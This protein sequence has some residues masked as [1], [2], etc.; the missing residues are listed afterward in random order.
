[1]RFFERSVNPLMLRREM[2]FKNVGINLEYLY[3]SL[4]LLL[5]HVKIFPSSIRNLVNSLTIQWPGSCVADR[6]PH[7]FTVHVLV[8]A[9]QPAVH[10]VHQQAF[11]TFDDVILDEAQSQCSSTI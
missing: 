9:S 7:C 1:M 6:K 4:Q 10:F 5:L 3:A 11:G 8:D 2:A